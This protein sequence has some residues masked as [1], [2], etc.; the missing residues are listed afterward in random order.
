M[1]TGASFNMITRRQII[2]SQRELAKGELK[3]QQQRLNTDN[4]QFNSRAGKQSN[5][6]QQIMEVE[7]N[8]NGNRFDKPSSSAGGQSSKASSGYHK[9]ADQAAGDFFHHGQQYSAGPN[10]AN[11]YNPSAARQAQQKLSDYASDQDYQTSASQMIV[12]PHEQEANIEPAYRQFD[13][14]SVYG[15]EEEDVWY[16]EE[17]LFE[18]SCA[19]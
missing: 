3:Q 10:R 17:R 18:V 9:A 7:E 15:D 14:Y 8:G 13:P 1:P 6:R 4:A 19:P 5:Y 2:E 16:S 11:R 12:E